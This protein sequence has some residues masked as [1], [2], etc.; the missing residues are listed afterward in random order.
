M[1]WIGHNIR[2]ACP[3]PR[4]E[5]RV[6]DTD[7][8]HPVQLVVLSTGLALAA[9]VVFVILRYLLSPLRS[10]PGSFLACFSDA[11]YLWRVN[12]IARSIRPKGMDLGAG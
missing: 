3:I 9:R 12:N 8:M 1:E 6:F 4:V 7:L 2:T 10:V 5:P 11:W